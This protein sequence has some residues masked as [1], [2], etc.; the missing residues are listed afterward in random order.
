MLDGIMLAEAQDLKKASI[1]SSVYR[2]PSEFKILSNDIIKILSEKN[3]V[4]PQSF[5]NNDT[6][7]NNIIVGQFAKVGQLDL[8]VLCSS[9][10]KSNI[11]IFWGGTSSCP[12]LREEAEDQ[13]YIYKNG[14]KYE[15]YRAILTASRNYIGS[16][17]GKNPLVNDNLINHDGIEDAWLERGSV[18]HYCHNGKWLRLSG[19][20]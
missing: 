17:N 13:M 4:I 7:L 1:P 5:N 16:R 6:L 8:A 14:Q 15:Y 20:D 18:I 11:I 10:N 19:G 12:P 2:H 9:A 3:C